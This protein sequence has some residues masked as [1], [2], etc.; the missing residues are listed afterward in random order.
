MSMRDPHHVTLLQLCN[1]MLR[2]SWRVL[3]IVMICTASATALSLF[4]ARTYTSVASFVPEAREPLSEETEGSAL[5]LEMLTGRVSSGGLSRSTRLSAVS[6][7]SVRLSVPSAAQ[8]VDPAFYSAALGSREVLM[9]VA[10]SHFPMRTRSGVRSGSVAD[11]YDLPPGPMLDRTEDAARRLLRDIEVSYDDRS[12][13]ITVGVRTTDPLFSQAVA[14]RLL[15][16]LREGNR[17]MADSRAEAQVAFLTRVAADARQELAIAQ[18]RLTAFLEVNRAYVPASPLTMSY[19][20]LDRDVLEKRRQYADLAL[21]LERAKLDRSRATQL[22]TVVS[23]PEVPSGPDPRGAARA[24]IA[25]AVGG[26]ALAMLLVLTSAQ[27]RRLRAAGF[28]DLAVLETEW[29]TALRR[30]ASEGLAN[31]TTATARFGAERG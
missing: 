8:P 5:P 25:G 2:R 16:V 27:L 22:I 4:R 31:P 7:T 15:D 29:R 30:G 21:Q 17:R 11:F 14:A 28:A 26:G 3:A 19:R 1:D 20:R 24:T 6:G 10:G 23:S 12:G 9:S 18:N 13:I